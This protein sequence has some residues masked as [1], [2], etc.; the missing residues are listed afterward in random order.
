MW[1]TL[2]F[3]VNKEVIE[4]ESFRRNSFN[5]I[6]FKNSYQRTPSIRRVLHPCI[7]RLAKWRK[8]PFRVFRIGHGN[9]E[10][11]C[12]T[13]SFFVEVSALDLKLVGCFD[14][15]FVRWHSHNKKQYRIVSRMKGNSFANSR[16]K[17]KLL[18]STLFKMKEINRRVQ[19]AWNQAKI[20]QCLRS[21]SFDEKLFEYV[22]L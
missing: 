10:L 3:W 14:I 9:L 19:R 12:K 18:N 6:D 7:K 11:R 2:F 20:T 13:N 1:I 15:F 22:W 16:S 21:T 17:S 5:Q 8:V 4:K